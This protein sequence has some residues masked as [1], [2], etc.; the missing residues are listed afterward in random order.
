MF[1]P[2]NNASVEQISMRRYGRY[3]KPYCCNA[4]RMGVCCRKESACSMY[5]DTE[6]SSSRD[7]K[8]GSSCT[9]LPW[10]PWI[11]S[12]E[13]RTIC[14]RGKLC[15]SDDCTLNHNPAPSLLEY[16]CI[17]FMVGT[18]VHTSED[19]ILHHHPWY[20]IAR[21]C[22]YGP[23]CKYRPNCPFNHAGDG[24]LEQCM[25]Q[26]N[27][28]IPTHYTDR[29]SLP[30]ALLPHIPTSTL[31]TEATYEPYGIAPKP[32]LEHSPSTYTH[33][34][35]GTRSSH[36]SIPHSDCVSMSIE[37]CI[38]GHFRAEPQQSSPCRKLPVSI[39]CT[40]TGNTYVRGR[41]RSNT[42]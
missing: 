29:Y 28:S 32:D 39:P 13:D 38:Y 5:H 11:H 6:Y 17:A 20:P 36:L 25:Q 1:V 37:R 33:S 26:H 7:C 2:V 41:P 8:Y 22:K 31:A 27:P 19:C 12:M 9:N 40:D 10:C 34:P 21:D 24:R 15:L 3:K 14:A 35:Y 4:F 42:I 30:H 16:C 23:T 18:C